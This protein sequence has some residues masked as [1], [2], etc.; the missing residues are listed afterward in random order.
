[1]RRKN[2]KIS[3]GFWRK[4]MKKTYCQEMNLLIAITNNIYKTQKPVLPEGEPTRLTKKQRKQVDDATRGERGYR[5]FEADY[6]SI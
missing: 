3:F 2:T 1:M 5:R 4:N 6:T